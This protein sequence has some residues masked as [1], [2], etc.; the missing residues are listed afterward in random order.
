[1][2]GLLNSSAPTLKLSNPKTLSKTRIPKL[3]SHTHLP[4]NAPTLIPSNLVPKNPAT[5]IH[6]LKPRNSH[7]VPRNS[8]PHSLTLKLSHSQTLKPKTHF[9]AAFAAGL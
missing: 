8:P 7:L 3:S 1:M 2:V 6:T 4:S 9:F 5:L